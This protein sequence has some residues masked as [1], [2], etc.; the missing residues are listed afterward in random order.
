MNLELFEKGHKKRLT[1]EFTVI[2]SAIALLYA[3]LCT[4]LNLVIT[5]DIAFEGTPL[6][7]LWD[8][9]SLLCNYLFYWIAFAYLIYQSYRYGFSEARPMLISYGVIVLLRYFANQLAEYLTI[10][11][12]VM[13][14][15]F[16]DIRELFVILLLEFLL[17]GFAVLLILRLQR[18]AEERQMKPLFSYMPILKLTE[19]GN[20]LLGVILCVS[21]IPAGVQFVSRIIFDVF[22]GGL[23]RGWV[24]LLWMIVYYLSDFINVG[25]G[26]AVI[27]LL[28][29]RLFLHEKKAKNDFDNGSLIP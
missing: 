23:P 16:E 20:P 14:D 25:I 7:L 1:L 26:Y 17:I 27:V 8:I 4:P 22:S 28:L 3:A 10:G 24:D 13:D 5:S 11:F 18:R 15:L 29:N 2:L 19:K 21:A 6:P 9:F 12:P